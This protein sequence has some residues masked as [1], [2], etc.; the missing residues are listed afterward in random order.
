[1]NLSYHVSHEQFAPSQLLRL[2]VAAE[3]AGFDA[4]FS[5][6]HF[7]PWSR[8]QGHS[9]FSWSWLGAALQATHRL[10]FSAI[11]VPGGWRYR[12]AVLAQAVATLAEMFPDRMPWI[13]LGSGQALNE[14]VAGAPWPDADTRRERLRRAAEVMARLLQG[15]HVTQ[16]EGLATDARLW[17]RPERAPRLVIAATTPQTAA[18]A[19]TWASGLLTVGV[20]LDRL[21]AIARVFRANA[22][23]RRPMHLKV[24][25]CWA[26]N[27]DEALLQA[28]RHWRFNALG[29]PVNCTLSRPEDFE[30]ATAHLTPEDLRAHVL[31][32]FDAVA[33]AEH[34]RA[35]AA[36]GFE[37]LDLHHVGPDQA[38]FLEWFRDRLRPLL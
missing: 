15:E 8:S 6:D 18:W 12:P 33:V 3:A 28:H 37:T 21:A 24:D 38:G 23:A 11:T 13:A 17:S 9:G 5:S 29:N 1:M 19:G 2:V 16:E 36:L 35:C 4:A 32:A 30:A 31:P 34:L 27:E 10:R 7:N 22:P 25:L 26:A 20:D 14:C